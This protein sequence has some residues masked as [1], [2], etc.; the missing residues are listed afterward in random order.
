MR[1][2]IVEYPETEW[3]YQSW[4]VYEGVPLMS[5]IKR[6]NR[7]GCSP[8]EVKHLHYL[9][10]KVWESKYNLTPDWSFEEPQDINRKA[11]IKVTKHYESFE[12]FKKDHEQ[13]MRS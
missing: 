3:D 5:R 1:Y 10:K 11:K 9:Y 8:L 7:A 4:E 13:L 6:G 2:I 12:D